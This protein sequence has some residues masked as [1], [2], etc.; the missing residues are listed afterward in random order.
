M[1]RIGAMVFL[2][3]FGC[4]AQVAQVAER[5]TISGEVV[6]EGKPVTGVMLNLQP[7]G[8]GMP[9][10]IKVSE[11]TFEAEVV[12]GMYSFFL[13]AGK[14]AKLFKKIPEEY[15]SASMD[16]QYDVADGTTLDLVID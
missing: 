4:G 9:A 16:R 13:S 12:P 8:D 14:N 7:T 2:C 5:V 6:M 10:V 3:C 15:L 11:G 1:R